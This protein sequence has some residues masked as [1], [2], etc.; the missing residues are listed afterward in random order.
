MGAKGKYIFF[1]LCNEDGPNANLGRN[2]FVS[3]MLEFFTG[4]RGTF[5]PFAFVL[6]RVQPV[7]AR[8]QGS[9]DEDSDAEMEDE[10]LDDE[11]E[12]PVDIDSAWSLQRILDHWESA[13]F[14]R[15]QWMSGEFLF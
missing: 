9:D 13:V 11:E 12:V 3:N 5:G 7:G 4:K 8:T 1:G 2:E 14:E 6:A 10:C 15:T